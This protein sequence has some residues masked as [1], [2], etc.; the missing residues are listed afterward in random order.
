MDV[1]VIL[2]WKTVA[3]LGASVIGTILVI[4][5]D[6][7]KAEKVSAHVVDAAKDFAIASNSNR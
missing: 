2:N 4:K 7:D 1:K 5:L 3:A 6:A